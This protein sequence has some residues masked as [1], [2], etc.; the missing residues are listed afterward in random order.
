MIIEQCWS[1]NRTAL[2]CLFLKSKRST[3]TNAT[4][5]ILCNSRWLQPVLLSKEFF[6]KVSSSSQDKHFENLSV[7][8]T[9]IL[10]HYALQ[11]QSNKMMEDHFQ[12]DYHILYRSF[13]KSPAFARRN[14]TSRVPQAFDHLFACI[15]GAEKIFRTLFETKEHIW[16]K[17]AG[18]RT[19]TA[20]SQICKNPIAILNGF[21]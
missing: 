12:T 18:Q 9:L 11:K 7:F 8:F 2:L 3:M 4:C 20:V 15:N 19:H 21:L 5:N 13:H 17:S 10:L 16:W 14:G 1:G 6:N